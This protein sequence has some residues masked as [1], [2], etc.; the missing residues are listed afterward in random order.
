MELLLQRRPTRSNFM[1]GDLFINSVWECYTLEDEL[2]QIKVMHHTAIPAGRYQVVA[3][4]SPKFGPDTLTLLNVPNF[5][6]IRIHC[7]NKAEDTDGCL[8]LGQEKYQ[9]T[10][11]RSREAVQALKDKVLEIL[12]KGEKVYISIRNSPFEKFIDTGAEANSNVVSFT[13]KS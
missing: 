4:V 7:G 11:G 10:I 8:L 2:R 13:R 9:N 5:S 12:R 3:E 6:L 1:H